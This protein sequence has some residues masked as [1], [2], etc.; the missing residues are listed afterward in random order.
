[1]REEN[2]LLIGQAANL[3]PDATRGRQSIVWLGMTLVA[4]LSAPVSFSG[5]SAVWLI[6][7][8]VMAAIAL[9]N[10]YQARLLEEPQRSLT[11]LGVAFVTGIVAV[12]ISISIHS[13]SG[14]FLLALIVLLAYVSERRPFVTAALTVVLVP[15]W[16]WLAADAWRWSLLI[17]VPLVGLGLMAV[18]HLLDAHA[19]P[20]SQARWM[21]ARAHRSAAWI[22]IALAG[23]LLVTAGLIADVHRPW[24]A[25]AGIVLAAAIPLEAGIGADSG[26]SARPGVRIVTGAWLI[27]IACWLIGI[28]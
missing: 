13:T 10:V 9:V 21:P 8:A 6:V 18:S 24:L 7:A 25:L 22:M 20:E 4:L 28:A 16:V 3:L 1:M 2:R 11:H 5:W 23:V 19:W 14:L 27:A 26:G 12:G 15:W 17:L